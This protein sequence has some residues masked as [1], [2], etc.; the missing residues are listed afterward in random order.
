[1]Q[2]ETT[3]RAQVLVQSLFFA[4][5]FGVLA[6]TLD[7][8][9][10]RFAL[11]DNS[12][13]VFWPLNGVTTALLLSK[14]R[15]AWPL[16]LL[17]VCAATTI[18]QA[19]GS[20]DGWGE[21]AVDSLLNAVEV[22]VA[23]SI[24]PQFASLPQWLREKHL[25][26]RFFLGAFLAGP[27][28]S[29]LLAA[30]YYHHK[31]PA[32]P[33]WHIFHTWAL[34]D[35][36]GMASTIPLVLAICRKSV[37][38]FSQP[39]LTARTLLMLAL[40]AGTTIGVFA[41]AQYT[42]LF[43]LFPVLAMVMFYTG[44]VGAMMAIEL[45]C[46]ISVYLTLHQ[47]GATVLGGGT[48][49]RVLFV[50]LFLSYVVMLGF[51]VSVL[52]AER[53]ATALKLSSRERQYRLLA[54]SSR[55][56]IILTDFNGV[57]DFV[58]P[59]CH[60][61][62]GFEP[63]DLVGQHFSDG[64]HPDDIAVCNSTLQDVRLGLSADAVLTY[65]TLRQSGEYVWVEGALRAITEDGSGDVIGCLVTVRDISEHKRLQQELEDAC[66]KLEHQAS[67]DA[68]TNVANRRR[69]DDI[70]DQEWRRAAREA[71]PLALM[72]VDIDNFKTYNDEYGHPAGD[73]CLRAVAR[74]LATLARRPGDL[75]ARYGGEEFAILLPLTDLRGSCEL[76]EK[77][78]NAVAALELQFTSESG[79][80]DAT[81]EVRDPAQPASVQADGPVQAVVTGR[82]TISIGCAAVVPGGEAG[83]QSL[84]EE[85]DRALYLAK[86]NGR[87]RVEAKPGPRPVI[88]ISSAIMA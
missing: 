14:K 18:S 38:Q 43:L 60:E 29:G 44:F 6:W 71:Q 9:L 66:T 51:P 13:A 21:A 80:P 1:M 2:T 64:I 28:A 5:F 75:V 76:G 32:D 3:P 11:L 34:A 55:D 86:A 46:V 26:L 31:H 15:K 62:L 68:L 77:I 45:I 72:L 78:R 56:I 52:L 74:T 42:L 50:Q 12:W 67:F 25:V 27:G 39:L 73:E 59:A 65:R 23:A 82:I 54:E 84:I 57:R 40:T 22:L 19:L 30:A 8:L 87:N 33:F 83:P 63:A 20:K 17:F 49:H 81:Q 36:L 10:S 4:L 61:I 37:W 58:S 88:S 7:G 47:K 24:L 53:R 70:F 35:A 85:A 79:L 69:F 48:D 16:L 41:K